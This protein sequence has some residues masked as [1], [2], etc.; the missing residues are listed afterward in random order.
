[1]TNGRERNVAIGLQ[2]KVY[3]KGAHLG[4]MMR[5]IVQR[6]RSLTFRSSL[7]LILLAEAVTIFVAWLLLG[8][9]IKQWLSSKASQTAQISE[10]VASSADWGRFY[11]VAENKDSALFEHYT[12][13]L[14]EITKRE[15]PHK[16]G[17]VYLVRVDRGKAWE[18]DPDDTPP[19]TDQGKANGFELTAYATEKMTAASS[20]IT[21]DAGTYLA[22]YT[23]ILRN[24]QVMGLLA[25]EY[26]TAS[27]ADLHEVVNRAFWYSV[28]PGVLLS[29][30]IAYVLAGMFVEPTDVFRAIEET[31]KARSEQPNAMADPWAGLTQREKDVAE[32]A[33][34]G[35]KNHEIAARLSVSIETVK[36]HM[37]SVLQ[38]QGCTRTDL[39]VQGYVRRMTP[40]PV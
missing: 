35:L 22:A 10:Q 23:P 25:A 13:Q 36:S 4:A 26:D 24:G 17:S 28:L 12:K 27:L 15:F 6:S 5:A 40:T 9:N 11:Q 39:A 1:M 31:A 30:V 38:K 8:Y 14:G 16:S 37:K 21:D 32:L 3:Q 34:Q 20:P 2:A 33:A 7:M 29:A 19:M 18:I